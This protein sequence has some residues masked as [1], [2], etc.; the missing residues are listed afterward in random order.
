MAQTQPVSLVRDLAEWRCGSAVNFLADPVSRAL[1]TL[2]NVTRELA[3]EQTLFTSSQGK[4]HCK[5]SSGWC[6]AGK[7]FY[8]SVFG[9]VG[10]PLV[11]KLATGDEGMRVLQGER[12]T[13]RW[14]CRLA[15]KESDDAAVHIPWTSPLFVTRDGTAIL[16][17]QRIPL[18]SARW[19]RVR[20][21][22]YFVRALFVDDSPVEIGWQAAARRTF[23][24]LAA[25]ERLVR[26][27]S[28]Y[29]DD[30][31]F[32]RSRE[33]H[34]WLLDPMSVEQTSG[35]HQLRGLSRP[36]NGD[37]GGGNGGA[38]CTAYHTR[39]QSAMLLSSALLAALAAEGDVQSLDGALCQHASCELGCTL[40]G[41]PASARVTLRSAAEPLRT[42][43]LELMQLLDAMIGETAGGRAGTSANTRDA[44]GLGGR[45]G[46]G[47]CARKYAAASQ[48]CYVAGG[49]GFLAHELQLQCIVENSYKGN[50]PMRRANCAG[51]PLCTHRARKL[52]AW[53]NTTK[54]KSEWMDVVYGH[55]SNSALRFVVSNERQRQEAC[56]AQTL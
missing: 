2:H 25:W 32:Q 26:R 31:Q 28:L 46:C 37:G 23:V 12:D 16:L 18:A 50:C 48:T 33:G 44:V 10:L 56:Q 42:E 47:P 51:A 22:P 38:L 35:E 24:Q 11:V 9:R 30:L 7:G 43:A 53:T 20:D 17:Q 3:S 4:R 1:D 19:F 8:K 41:L 21:G 27:H 34:I 55:P 54:L 36:E 45:G 52:Q 39:R 14:L 15:E 40:V 6:L 5:S 29:I 49:E 13:M